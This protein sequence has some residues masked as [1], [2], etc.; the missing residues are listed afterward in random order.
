MGAGKV[1]PRAGLLPEMTT[2][3][4]IVEQGSPA[5]LNVYVQLR[6]SAPA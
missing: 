3:M 4:S 5:V 1:S 6:L 2:E